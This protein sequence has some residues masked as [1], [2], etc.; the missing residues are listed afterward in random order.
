MVHQFFHSMSPVHRRPTACH[1]HHAPT[2]QRFDEHPGHARAL[3]S[4]LVVGLRLLGGFR[5]NRSP[6]LAC[7]LN[8]LLI[9]A[10]HRP[11][12]VIR[13]GIDVQ[14]LLH[15]SHELAVLIRRPAQ[16]DHKPPSAGTT[17]RAA[18]VSARF[19]QRL[20]HGLVR[21]RIHDF[22]L[23]H[24]IGQQPQAPFRPALGGVEQASLVM[25]ASTRPS[26]LVG[27]TSRFLRSSTAIGPCW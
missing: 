4:V 16:P 18:R 27:L 19:L 24:P 13:P 22:E 21:E 26:T 3:A 2:A 25:C 7:Q 1:R 23:H 6:R 8:G 12:L 11:P 20:P 5:R 10:D 14:N 15:A 17:C 9:H